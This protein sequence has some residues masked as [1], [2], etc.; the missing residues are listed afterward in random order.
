MNVRR[1]AAPQPTQVL[2]ALTLVTAALTNAR[3]SPE[4]SLSQAVLNI[5]V[6]FFMVVMGITVIHKGRAGPSFCSVRQGGMGE[7]GGDIMTCEQPGLHGQ[8]FFNN[9]FR[10]YR[11][12][13]SSHSF[14]KQPN[15]P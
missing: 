11:I 8:S 7:R 12:F 15:V 13:E 6:V 9:H 2:L 3:T 10:K 4:Y 14:E 5:L 1:H